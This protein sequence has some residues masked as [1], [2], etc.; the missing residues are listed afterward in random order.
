MKDKMA[1][2]RLLWQVFLIFS[3]ELASTDLYDRT[4]QRK[5][6]SKN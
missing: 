2:I 1:R 4:L 3:Q 5:Y 6:I